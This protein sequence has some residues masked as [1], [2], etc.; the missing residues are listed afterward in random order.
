MAKDACFKRVLYQEI[1]QRMRVR[2]LS[3]SPYT[4]QPAAQHTKLVQPDNEYSCVMCWWCLRHLGL[5]SPLAR[6]LGEFWDR[7]SI[8][9]VLD[10]LKYLVAS[11]RSFRIRVFVLVPVILSCF[12]TWC[13]Q[14]PGFLPVCQHRLTNKIAETRLWSSRPVQTWN[15]RRLVALFIPVGRRLLGASWVAKTKT[16]TGGC[17]RGKPSPLI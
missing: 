8:R 5:P 13:L 12:S 7:V 17:A 15:V 2:S 11:R 3:P 9:H 6:V 14:E 16:K 10:L 1:K 4:R